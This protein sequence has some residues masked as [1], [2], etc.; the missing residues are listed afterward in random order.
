MFRTTIRR[1]VL[2]A[3]VAGSA[4]VA[5]A[6]ATL[7]PGLTFTNTSGLG[8][9]NTTDLG[10]AGDTIALNGLSWGE[11]WNDPCWM[12]ADKTD[13]NLLAGNNPDTYDHCNYTSWDPL[14]W[15]NNEDVFVYGVQVCMN[16]SADRL[17]GIRLYGGEIHSD[18]TITQSGHTKALWHPNC[19]SWSTSVYCDPG[20]VATKLRVHHNGDTIVGLSLGCRDVTKQ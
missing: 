14:G 18:G 11:S 16:S 1:C 8:G 20:Q 3:V 10:A 15:E 2:V 7:V 5:L 6:D 4:A 12:R 9:S 17:K 19:A 13:I